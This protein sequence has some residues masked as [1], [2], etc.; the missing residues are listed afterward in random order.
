MMF[1]IDALEQ[2]WRIEAACVGAP[3]GVFFPVPTGKQRLP[4]Y[5]RSA[6]AKAKRFCNA[7]PVRAECLDFAITNGEREGVWGG[8]LFRSGHMISIETQ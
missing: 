1:A 5:T 8:V 3:P 2:R 7:C 4:K 6:A